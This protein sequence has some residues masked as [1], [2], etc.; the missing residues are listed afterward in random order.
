MYN[1]L[2]TINQTLKYD[3]LFL[4]KL[5]KVGGVLVGG[6]SSPRVLSPTMG[7]PSRVL[8]ATPSLDSVLGLP[9]PTDNKH[10]DVRSV[11]IVCN[12]NC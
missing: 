8:S 7:V 2:N 1:F 4:Q 10:E 3:Y 6:L 12:L 9:A 11:S 5:G